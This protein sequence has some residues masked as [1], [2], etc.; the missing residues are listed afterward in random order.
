MPSLKN[1]F[2]ENA[3]N[4]CGRLLNALA[5]QCFISSRTSSKCAYDAAIRMQGSSR[6]ASRILLDFFFDVK[7][8]EDILW[9]RCDFFARIHYDIMSLRSSITVQSNTKLMNI[10]LKHSSEM[11]TFDIRFSE[12]NL[13]ARKHIR[14]LLNQ[15]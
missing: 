9:N 4:M 13:T 6:Q 3:T 14:L 12:L 11:A 2:K 1:K 5:I 10:Q 8:V 7:F 15:M